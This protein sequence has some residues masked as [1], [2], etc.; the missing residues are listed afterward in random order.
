MVF[1]KTFTSLKTEPTVL[2]PSLNTAKFDEYIAQADE[3]LL[4]S[5][6][7]V[8]FLSINRYERKKNLGLVIK[9]YGEHKIT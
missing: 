5:K 1:R 8:E 6:K 4:R 7:R 3:K 2:Y 9:A